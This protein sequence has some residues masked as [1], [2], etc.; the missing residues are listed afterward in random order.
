V[1]ATTGVVA[2]GCVGLGGAGDV[3][4][5]GDDAEDA[6]VGGADPDVV[7][8]GGVVPAPLEALEEGGAAD[9][10]V[11]GEVPLPAVE[12]LTVPE[13]AFSSATPVEVPAATRNRRRA[14]NIESAASLTAP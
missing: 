1:L 8:A 6:D 14:L 10:G 4:A 9:G 2:M 13:Q 5:G 12:V 11:E 3:D 7:G